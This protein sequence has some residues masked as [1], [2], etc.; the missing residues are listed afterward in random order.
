LS[1]ETVMADFPRE[2]G[3]IWPGASAE[4]AR[5]VQAA[6]ENADV[7]VSDLYTVRDWLHIADYDEEILHALLLV[8]IMGAAEGSLCTEL[9]RDNLSR[10]LCDLVPQADADQWSQRIVSELDRESFPRLIG[11]TAN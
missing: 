10:R 5:L 1:T 11:S 3:T 4:L 7:L 2:A 9:S 6:R 8:H